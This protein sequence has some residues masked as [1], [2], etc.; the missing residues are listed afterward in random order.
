MTDGRNIDRRLGV[1]EGEAAGIASRHPEK[2]RSIGDATLARVSRPDIAP[3]VSP[4]YHEQPVLKAPVWKAFIP[5]YFFVGGLTGGA[6]V[7]AAAAQAFGGRPL[8]PLVTPARWLAAGGTVVSAALL[9]ADLG[10]PTRF[11]NMMRVFRPTSPM[12][13][14]TWILS[15]AGATMTA[16]AAL[17]ILGMKRLG[18]VAGIAAAP[19]G[20]G[21]ASYTGVLVAYSAVPVWSHASTTL[22][23]L[24]VSSAAASAAA[25]LDVVPGLPPSARA[26][27]RVLGN[28]GRLAELVCGHAYERD[29]EARGEVVAK[30][31]REGISGTLFTASKALTGAS[32]ALSIASALVTRRSASPLRVASGVLGMAGALALRFAVME[33]GRASARDPRAT[34]EPQRRDREARLRASVDRTGK[35]EQIG[36]DVRPGAAI[37]NPL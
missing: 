11:L 8:R 15:G 27:V 29:V 14:G 9:I 5:T 19:F 10:R 23:P 31:L 6:S 26:A 32:L 17:P 37:P 2:A 13:V 21:L 25:A 7:L 30:P 24:F 34:F 28:V 3:D 36:A 22:P 35:T 4:T 18:D 16:A 12:N 1:L 33:A 20:L